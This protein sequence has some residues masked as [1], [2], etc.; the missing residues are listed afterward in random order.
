MATTQGKN[1]LAVLID[2]DNAQPSAIE[3]ARYSLI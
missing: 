1:Q 2:A 3:S